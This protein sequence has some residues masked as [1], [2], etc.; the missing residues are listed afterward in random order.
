MANMNVTYSEMT[1]AATRL[2]TGK[3]DLVSKLTEL[4]TQVNSL[5]QNGF[6]TDQASGAFQTSYDQFTKGT[7]E[8]VNGLEGMSQFLTKAAEALGNVDSELAKGIS[9]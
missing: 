7:T 2:T 6:V 4:Q 1:D 3:E 5:V 8:A 9:G